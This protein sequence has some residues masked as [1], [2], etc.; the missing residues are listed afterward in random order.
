MEYD[1]VHQIWNSDTS[2]VTQV[3]PEKKQKKDQ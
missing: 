3:V 1:V 2:H